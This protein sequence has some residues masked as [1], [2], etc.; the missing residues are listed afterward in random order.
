MKG[1]T[2]RFTSGMYD[3]AVQSIRW[4]DQVLP[5]LT[6]L[7]RNVHIEQ[8]EYRNLAARFLNLKAQ[9]H[10]SIGQDDEAAECERMAAGQ[11]AAADAWEG[12]EELARMPLAPFPD[13]E[14]DP[15][16][17]SDIDLDIR[18]G[19]ERAAGPDGAA[20]AEIRAGTYD[21]TGRNPSD[22]ETMIVM[23]TLVANG[24]AWHIGGLYFLTKAGEEQAK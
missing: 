3:R 4:I 22:M 24:I 1:Q 8:P 10:R 23:S 18:A 12:W 17:G 16:P 6:G 19:F 13:P 7:A 15:A 21:V 5:G 2:M 9:L 20:I 11:F 14:V